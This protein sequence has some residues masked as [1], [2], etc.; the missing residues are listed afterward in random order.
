MPHR[1]FDLL[2]YYNENYGHKDILFAY[3]VAGEW[4]KYSGK[5]FCDMTDAVSVSMLRKGIGKGD[6]IAIMAGNCP[7]WN[8]VDFAALQIGAVVVPVHCN[9]G[10]GD[11]D[12]ILSHSETKLIY[13]GDEAIYNRYKNVLDS[14]A[15]SLELCYMD[16]NGTSVETGN[17][18]EI[19]AT[20]TPDDIAT[21]IYTSGTTGKPKGVM[22]THDNIMSN[23]ENYYYHVPPIDRALSYLP[24]S[25]IFER[26]VQ[27]TRIYFGISIYYAENMATI[28]RDIIDV[29]A[30]SFSTVPRVLEKVYDAIY[31]KG[32]SLKGFKKK[33]YYWSLDVA[34]RYDETGKHN[35]WIYRKKLDFAKKHVL[36]GFKGIFGG[37]TVFIS[38]GGTSI[39]PRLVKFCSAMGFPIIE[40]YGLSE[41]SP[42]VSISSY[43]ENKIKA[44]S[45]GIICRNLDVK[46]GDNEEIMVKGSSVMKGYYK[47]EESTRLAFDQNGYF[48]TGDK[49]FID[50]EGFLF[51]KGRINEIFKTSMG[52][53]VSPSQIEGKLCESPWF[54]NAMVV[55]ENQKF[56]A[57]LII[58]DF[59]QI[60]KWCDENGIAYTSNEIMTSDRKVVERCWQEVEKC[61]KTLGAAE[62]VRRFVLL[63]AD[64]SVDG[65]Q[66]T[67]SMKVRRYVIMK[68]YKKQIEALFA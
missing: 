64:W 59:N 4:K 9:I 60:K 13:I 15:G 22:L 57:A 36:N 6:K 17:L 19:K 20:V 54:N 26:S 44:G 66:L 10:P 27:Y 33:L 65:G 67:P 52:K 25:H 30:N 28:M 2:P 39:Q 23:I 7:Q 37:E 43:T 40:G 11:L 29:K 5:V 3:K 42:M 45:V 16:F 34:N 46:I 49:G 63:D 18:D 35:S 1:I 38:S 32:E 41:T 56:V 61:N 8:M 31:K 21:I 58:P 12:Y 14:H 47:D 24:L 62:K 68:E 51:I 48:H 53:F 50:D 55:G